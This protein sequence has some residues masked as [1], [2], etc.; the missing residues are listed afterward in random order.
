MRNERIIRNSVHCNECDTEI[1]STHRHD[2]KY[3]PCGNIAVDGG[4]D[5][6]RRASG[7]PTWGDYTDTSIVEEVV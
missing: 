6:L 2:F 5:Y 7:R 1:E 4:K 3:C